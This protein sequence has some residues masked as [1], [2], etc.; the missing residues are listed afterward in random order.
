MTKFFE[1]PIFDEF[2]LRAPMVSEAE[3]QKMEPGARAAYV[4]AH[5]CAADVQEIEATIKQGE[6]DIKATQAAIDR[7]H[8]EIENYRGKVDAHSEWLRTVKGIKPEVDPVRE[9]LAV[10]A[11]KQLVI[12]QNDLVTKTDALAFSKRAIR[13]A[14]RKQADAWD[15]YVR[16]HHKIPSVSEA[17]HA[18]AASEAERRA[19]NVRAGRRPEQNAAVAAPEFASVV[20]AVRANSKGPIGFSPSVGGRPGSFPASHRGRTMQPKAQ[21]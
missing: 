9:A 11:E 12:L 5:K 4:Y 1:P 20:D 17:L 14:M 3:Q 16:K 7:Q 15:V 13:D 19:T 6:A 18:H 2:G 8:R 21:G 10:E